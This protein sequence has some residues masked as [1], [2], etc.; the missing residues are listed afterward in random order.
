MLFALI[1]AVPGTAHKVQWRMTHLTSKTF[2]RTWHSC[3]SN[4]T[5]MNVC[6]NSTKQAPFLNRP[7]GATNLIPMFSPM[8]PVGESHLS[9]TSFRLRIFSSFKCYL[10]FFLVFV[11]HH[12]N[13]IWLCAFQVDFSRVRQA[14]DRCCDETETLT[15]DSGQTEQAKG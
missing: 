7:P 11:G 10:P 15:W 3:S 5:F 1:T 8:L 4:L 14:W 9:L 2:A 13:C 6:V 12:A